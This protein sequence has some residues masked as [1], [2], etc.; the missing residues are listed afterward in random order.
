MC[1]AAGWRRPGQ[2]SGGCHAAWRSALARSREQRRACWRWPFSSGQRGHQ[3]RGQGACRSQPHP[4]AAARC[5]RVCAPAAGGR[6][7]VS[8]WH[9]QR[10]R[11]P[12]A[13]PARRQQQPQP[14]LVAPAA[15]GGGQRPLQKQPWR[16]VLA[17]APARHAR[18]AEPCR[19]QRHRAGRGRRRVSAP[20]G[21][22][23]LYGS[24]V[25]S[26]AAPVPVLVLPQ[27][28]SVTCGPAQHICLYACT[29]AVA[30][31]ARAAG[32]CLSEHG[33]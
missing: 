29:H 17:I 3:R 15:A 5:R 2:R 27:R 6:W 11:L 4:H 28:P 30:G 19:G 10:R 18:H 20:H 23:S 9:P 26:S 21:P 14:Q 1:A 25:C 13:A 24:I 8:F 12:Q 7:A 22:P 33:R 16:P 31:S 32:C